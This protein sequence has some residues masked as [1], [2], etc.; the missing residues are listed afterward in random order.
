MT[1]TPKPAPSSG[2]GFI[3]MLQ[4]K[5]GGIALTD[6][7][8]ALAEVVSRVTG[9]RKKG[10]LTLT[11][12]IKPN[13]KRGVQVLDRF[14]CRPVGAPPPGVNNSPPAAS[15]MLVNT[16]RNRYSQHAENATCQSCHVRIDGIGFGLEGYDVLGRRRTTENGHPIDE[17]GDV[18]L[19]ADVD[20]PFT[21]ALEL[22]DKLAASED[23]TRCFARHWYEYALAA[24][25]T[26]SN[27]LCTETALAEELRAAGGAR[28]FV[29][30]LVRSPAFLT[31]VPGEAP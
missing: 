19:G 4:Q 8:Q 15:G 23:S 12:T 30:R 16:T 9:T 11:I 13:A 17:R 20:G 18:R 10:K 29:V 14:L 3:A 5:A 26:G 7:D 24:P 27:V 28:E 22:A 1:T 31:R 2:G 6:L 21:G 25:P